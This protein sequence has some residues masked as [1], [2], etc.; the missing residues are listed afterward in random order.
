MQKPTL[1]TKAACLQTGVKPHLLDHLANM[2]S[3][4]NIPLIVTDPLIEELA[5]KYYPYTQ[6]IY[7]EERRCSLAFL[8]E[9]F[10]TL[11][12]SC[13][14]FSSELSVSI[15]KLFHQK[16][17]F[18]YLPHGNSDKGWL[19]PSKDPLLGGDLTFLYGKQMKQML[20]DR[21]VLKT[22]NGSVTTGNYRLRCYQNNR[23]IL[24]PLIENE[25][26]SKFEKKQTTLLYA[27]TYND[28]EN[29]SSFIEI[30]PTLLANVPDHFNVIVKLH[31]NLEEREPEKVYPIIGAYEKKNIMFLKEMPLVYPL[32]SHVDLYLGDFSSVGYDFLSFNKP[33]YFINKDNRKGASTSLF[34][35]G[36][37]IPKEEYGDVFSFIEK[38]L[39]ENQKDKQAARKK[40][41]E[42]CFDPTATDQSILEDVI[43]Y[44]CK[45]DALYNI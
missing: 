25:I 9:N 11:I 4:L 38:T 2:A 12:V 1:L 13:K 31:P 20:N 16:I 7:I 19:D 37:E 29:S 30:G 39:Q 15:A 17:H 32:L 5:R 34:Q 40:L 18:F 43:E 24:D 23:P 33:L 14:H 41:Y 35:A 45:K 36:I 21:G 44:T 22:L 6:T 8:K 28:E 10:N 42:N 26:F 3:I 27:P